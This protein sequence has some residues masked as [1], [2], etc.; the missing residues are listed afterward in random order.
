M[1]RE[2]TAAQKQA[3][4]NRDRTLLVSAA[5]GS[6]KTATL[7]ERIIRTL[8]DPVQKGDISRMLVVTFT[9][10]A[11][12]ELRDRISDA[13]NRAIAEGGQNA[14]LS[15]QLL[16]LPGAHISTIDSFCLDLVRA[17]A[18]QIGLSPAF[19]LADPTENTLLQRSV[20][21]RLIDECYEG[22]TDF[23]SGEE[24]CALVD[25]LTGTRGDGKLSDILLSLYEKT[26]G[27]ARGTRV[28]TDMTG[29][30]VAA[31]EKPPYDTPWGAYLR[32][33][34]KEII[35]A[36]ILRFREA[37]ARLATNPDTAATYMHTL[38]EDVVR[39]R[40]L[41]SAL[42]VSYAAARHALLTYEKPKLASLKADKKTEDAA[43]A[44]AMRN[45]FYTKAFKDKLTDRY[46]CYT[47][48]EWRTTLPR[49]GER[50]RLLAR[51]LDVFSD[52][53]WEEKKRRNICSFNDLSHGALRLLTDE[54]GNPTPFAAE[55][56]RSFDAVYVDEYQDVNEVQHRL[57]E[58]IAG[59]RGRFMVGDIKQSIYGFRGAQPEIFAGI[60]RDFPNLD[61]AG[62]SPT[63]ALSL[64]SNFRSLSPILD[65]TN[66]VF[67]RLMQAVGAHIGYREEEDAL[68]PE[69][70]TPTEAP[71]PRVTVALFEKDPSADDKKETNSLHVAEVDH[72]GV[73]D[74]DRE[75]DLLSEEE[76]DVETVDAE[77]RYVAREI[78][79]LLRSGRLIKDRPIRPGDIAII[80]RRS[81]PAPLFQQALAAYGIRAEATSRQ[82]F[83]VNPE[84]LLAL[85]L[86]NVVDNPRRDVHLAGVLRSP[87]YGFTM[88]ELIAIRRTADSSDENRDCTLYEALCLYVVS[89][90]DFEKGRAFL[91]ALAR[92]RRMAEGQPVDRLIWQLYRETGLLALAGADKDGSPAVRRANLM[93]L[94]DYA[95]RFEASSYRGLYNFIAYINETIERGKSIEEGHPF[96]ARTDTVSIMTIH[97]SK[98]LEFPICFLVDCG[99]RFTR[100]D[101][102]APLLFHRELGCALKLRDSTGL[103]RIANPVYHAVSDAMLTSGIEEQMR[104]LYVALTRPRDQ[105]YITATVKDAC[106]AYEKAKRRTGPLVAEQ[107][108][109]CTSFADMLLTAAAGDDSFDLLFPGECA[110]EDTRVSQSVE[111]MAETASDPSPTGN[112]AVTETEAVLRDRF[113][114]VYPYRHMGELPSKMSVSRLYPTALDESEEVIP[115]APVLSQVTP[116]GEKVGTRMS[117]SGE[118]H[119]A[120][121]PYV[122]DISAGSLYVD[123]PDRPGEDPAPD[124][125]YIPRFMG[126]VRDTAARAGTATHLFMQ[127]CNFAHLQEVGAAAELTRLTERRFLSPEDAALV[128]LDEVEAFLRSPLL[129][130]LTGEG[131]LYRELRFHARLP[132]AA[133]TADPDKKLAYG[134]ETVLVQGVMDGVLV[135]PDGEVWLFDYKTDRLT[136]YERAHPAAAAEKLCARHTMQLSYYAEACRD[137]FGRRPDRVM[138]YSLPLGDT[139]DVPVTPIT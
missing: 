85:S 64:S 125:R 15:R 54:A 67:G 89:N 39:L 73:A 60:R 20:L 63:A 117:P 108:Y 87:L 106:A 3:I 76:E 5:A 7:T 50:L 32:D 74:H 133:F 30:L 105:L 120:V 77:A 121:G 118:D 136:A 78:N 31:G 109:A 113:S 131:K 123:D 28:L 56:G 138:I 137:I 53:V 34:A 51:L 49:I 25:C 36:W 4:E 19:R 116:T 33:R 42:D 29:A 103:V 38:E 27:F 94:Y 124:H 16:L 111:K 14:H 98:G 62:D 135:R 112:A 91:D 90:P 18:A 93:M 1:A 126:G 115:A 35:E 79:G 58:L 22:T 129:S 110:A 10:S 66:L 26:L 40:A 92:Y 88:D 44:Q 47:E 23:C 102:T 100:Q 2:W 96:S 45:A 59:P 8:T 21:E 65:F 132:A 99:A 11:A 57:F 61:G 83:F 9:R 12:A 130:A 114:Y 101:L 71:A 134:D 46:F 86:L 48:E 6:G 13:L 70:A 119:P 80:M 41:L 55:I 95:R 81:A 52:R 127:F 128:R 43:E 82:G 97:Q 107:A 69:R 122:G 17:N 72:E 68:V 104:V 24:F 139:V 37:I 84:I 75:A